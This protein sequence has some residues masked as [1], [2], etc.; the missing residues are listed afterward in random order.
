MWP[1]WRFSPCIAEIQFCCLFCS[2]GWLACHLFHV[3]F[4]IK[5]SF[6]SEWCQVFYLHQISR[7][8]FDNISASSSQ[9]DYLLIT[10]F[11]ILINISAGCQSQ[12][13]I[14]TDEKYYNRLIENM[15][16]W[17]EWSKPLI[18]EVSP[19]FL[20]IKALN[21]PFMWIRWLPQHAGQGVTRTRRRFLIIFGPD[22][23]EEKL[24]LISHLASSSSL[25]HPL[26]LNAL[27]WP[28]GVQ[29]INN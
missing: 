26:S 29:D 3:E 24:S 20:I 2:W 7:V 17:E 8:C 22:S 27:S 1:V 9:S 5:A 21:K 25:Y 14:L 4:Q 11:V 15:N 10:T 6:M 12:C 19:A 13:I 16:Y 23:S 28:S 18:S